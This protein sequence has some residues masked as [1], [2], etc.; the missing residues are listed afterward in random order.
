MIATKDSRLSLCN[1]PIE[2]GR[3]SSR[4]LII[5]PLAQTGKN[6]MDNSLNYQADASQGGTF[7]FD[8]QIELSSFANESDVE[9]FRKGHAN[10]YIFVE[11]K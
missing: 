9:A 3:I 6:Q 11:G 2:E 7:V 5:T 1:Q 4:N 10:C 8:K